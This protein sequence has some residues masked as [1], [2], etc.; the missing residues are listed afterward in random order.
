MCH[1]NDLYG[2]W[3]NSSNF[4][5]RIL[6]INQF[7]KNPFWYYICQ[8][9]TYTEEMFDRTALIGVGMTPM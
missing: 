1:C 4:L 9:S 8:Y 5:L 3:F 6:A 7:Q 2:R